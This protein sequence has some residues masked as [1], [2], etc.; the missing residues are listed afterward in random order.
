VILIS[1]SILIVFNGIC[2]RLCDV[3]LDV[4]AVAPDDVVEDFGCELLALVVA[5]DADLY[6]LFV[7]EIAVVVHLAGDEGVGFV[8]DSVVEDEIA[9]TAADGYSPDGA[10][11]QLVAVGA[12]HVEALFDQC[13]KGVSVKGVG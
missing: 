10:L 8:S 5:D 7:T 6:L 12:S 2:I 13:D 9:G 1:N 11:E 3:G 4:R